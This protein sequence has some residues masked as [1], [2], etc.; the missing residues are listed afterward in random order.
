M[1]QTTT[2]IDKTVRLQPKPLDHVTL[3]QLLGSWQKAGLS[4][5]QIF[6]MEKLYLGETG[7]MNLQGEYPRNNFYEVAKGLRFNSVVELIAC[8]K[9]CRGFGFVW[10]CDQHDK[11]DNLSGL[12]SELWHVPSK[13]E[14][15]TY[16][17]VCCPDNNYYN[18]INNKYNNKYNNIKGSAQLN[19]EQVLADF[20]LY[21]VSEPGA[22]E[23]IVKPVNE[24][25][26]RMMPELK[27]EQEE[28]HPVNPTTPSQSLSAVTPS[29]GQPA[30]TPSQSRPVNPATQL[31]LK[32]YLG[33][34]LVS[35]GTKFTHNTHEGRKIWVI[36]LMRYPF[37]QRNIANAVADVRAELAHNA[38]LLARQYH[39]ISPHE[40][41]DKRSGQRFYDRQDPKSG[42]T[43]VEHIPDD[44]P[45][46]PSNQAKW[47][48]FDKKWN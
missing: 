13:D 28:G 20:L 27:V 7:W 26:E 24:Q 18:N 37:M 9:R 11:I 19:A 46:R 4:Y 22:Y 48:K 21:L 29:Q 38:M 41:K 14:D 47:D 10:M 34:Y 40:Y 3:R 42:D 25:T 31:F 45:A 5:A 23:A 30:A 16:S 43:I 6:K 1:T 35:K 33:Q 32:K 39:P 2:T 36:N 8:I 15:V 44:A 17:A 12:F